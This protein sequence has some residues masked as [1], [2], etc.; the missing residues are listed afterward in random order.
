MTTKFVRGGVEQL[1]IGPTWDAL[2]E[3]SR[4]CNLIAHGVRTH[5]KM[6]ESDDFVT[7]ESF[8]V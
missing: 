7:A 2:D 5:S 6:L 1:D 4:E 3:L 8:S